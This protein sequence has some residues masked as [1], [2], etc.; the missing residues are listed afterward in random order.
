MSDK[1]KLKEKDIEFI[2]KKLKNGDNIPDKYRFKIPFETQKEYELIYDGKERPEDII[3]NV[4][5]VPFQ[6]IKKF[7]KIKEEW[8]NKLIFG[9]NLQA[10][11][12]LLKLKSEGK[13]K[14]YDG[15]NGIKL[16]YID[17]PFGTGD[18]YDAKGAPAYSAKVQ[19]V[20][21]IDSVRNRIV[22]LHELLTDNG[23]IYVRIDYHFGHYVKVFIDEIFDKNNFKNELVIN[24]TQEFF[25]SSR[26]LTR[27]M[28]D[29][30][31]L[32]FYTK[33][34][35]YIFNELKVKREDNKWWEMT[36]PGEPKSE[37]DK[38][39]TVLGKK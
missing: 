4:I 21:F 2:Y 27:F 32:F 14:N 6:P 26:G 20:K 25:K 7:G 30:D 34:K 12:Y 31:S 24:R 28:V 36:L 10:L 39:I 1:Y 16:I 18:I 13:L 33:R 8:N 23:S 37:K 22:L 3:D 29:T 5:S 11:K 15:S 35:K 38:Y 17:P 19:G 9:D